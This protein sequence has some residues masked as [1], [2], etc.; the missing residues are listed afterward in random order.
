M[1]QRKLLLPPFHGEA[2]RRYGEEIA[3]IADRELDRWPV[4]EPFPLR[5]AMQAITLEVI[6]RTVFGVREPERLERFGSAILRVGETGNPLIW[7]PPL[8]RDLGRFSPA[9]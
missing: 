2:V 5:P 1:S 3:A 6:L 7:L 9:G 8:R 4:G